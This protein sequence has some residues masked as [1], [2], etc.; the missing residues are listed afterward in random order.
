VHVTYRNRAEFIDWQGRRI[1]CCDYAGLEEQAEALDAFDQVRRAVA[2]EPAGTVL[3]ISD[4]RASRLD[5]TMQ[6]K[7]MEL[8]LHNR[9]FVRAAAVVGLS[10]EQRRDLDD[11]QR[12]SQREFAVFDTL[13]AARDWLLA[14]G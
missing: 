6:R 12:V 8:T 5:R 10:A 7:L 14:Q 2:D 3:T 11:V 1:L 13:E 9:E 4:V